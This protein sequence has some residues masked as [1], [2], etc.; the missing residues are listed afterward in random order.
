MRT[1]SFL[2]RAWSVTLALA[3]IA[4]EL[5]GAMQGGTHLAFG[6]AASL[7][8][9]G[10]GGIGI[11]SNVARHHLMLPFHGEH[12]A[13]LTIPDLPPAAWLAMA[14]AGGLGSLLPDI[15][16][17]GSLLTR[18]PA[19]QGRTLQR[20]ARPYRDGTF[21]APA[22]LTV[23]TVATGT[24]L[25]SA[26][27]GAP[28]ERSGVVGRLLLLILACAL[29]MLA[30]SARWL[31]ANALRAWPVQTR[32]TLALMMGALSLAAL[33]LAFGGVAGLVHRLPG[34]HRGWTHAPPMALALTV[35]AFV[36]GPPLFPAL[37]GVGPAFAAGYLSHLAADA[38]TI[39][40][41]PLWWPGRDQP[42]LHLLP[43]PLRVRTG[44]MGERLFN[45]C[46]PIVL[47]AAFGLATWR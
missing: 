36:L 40:G 19:R 24:G 32:H 30:I 16:Q 8:A 42:S 38:L 3:A 10:L 4:G 25:A 45:L 31:P 26:L 29:G 39:R 35:A 21:G 46:W 9:I 37:P 6:T 33:L 22:R 23:D 41:I 28:A 43:R 20:L 2:W 1:R 13:I 47:V 34:H 18:M 17:P 11:G 7:A 27:L 15:D 44:G 14:L 12:P 5:G